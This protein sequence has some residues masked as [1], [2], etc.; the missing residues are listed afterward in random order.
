MSGR[1]RS[2]MGAITAALVAVA[3]PAWAPTST[4][5]LTGTFP[6]GTRTFGP[7]AVPTDVT[8]VRAD[9]KSVV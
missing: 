3:V 2:L 5:V 9:R 8:G 4:V 6:A 1:A 7:V